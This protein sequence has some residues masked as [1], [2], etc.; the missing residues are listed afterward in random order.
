MRTIFAACAVLGLLTLSAASVR[1]EP[2]T[3]LWRLCAQ[4]STIATGTL[5]YSGGDSVAFDVAETLKGKPT[6]HLTFSRNGALSGETVNEADR[7]VVNARRVLVFLMT[8]DVDLQ[9]AIRGPRHGLGVAA[10]D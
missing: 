9:P 7:S 3:E 1:S 10:R 4:S 6:A 5:S 8:T 2:A